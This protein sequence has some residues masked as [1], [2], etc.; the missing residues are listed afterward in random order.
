MS[1]PS[2]LL[3]KAR[4]YYVLMALRGAKLS[5]LSEKEKETRDILDY[6][7]FLITGR[8]DVDF[9]K[10]RFIPKKYAIKIVKFC[11]TIQMYARCLLT[12]YMGTGSFNPANA[13]RYLRISDL[14]HFGHLGLRLPTFFHHFNADLNLTE[15]NY[16][17]K[18]NW[19]IDTATERY[20][21]LFNYFGKNSPLQPINLPTIG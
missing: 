6:H 13:E 15:H 11:E 16:D 3:M 8:V 18:N 5:I 12:T 1:P 21:A 19:T 9:F 7:V 14:Q 17:E 2:S 20:L 10:N 4:I